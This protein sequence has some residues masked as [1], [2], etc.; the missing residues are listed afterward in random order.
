ML[1]PLTSEFFDVFLF[2][3]QK[4][5][6]DTPHSQ[7]LGHVT[8]FDGHEFFAGDNL[9]PETVVDTLGTQ[10]KRNTHAESERKRREVISMQ[11]KRMALNV[12]MPTAT[13]AQVM[14]AANVFIENHT[15]TDT[16]IGR[17]T[18]R[19]EAVFQASLVTAVQK[20]VDQAVAATVSRDHMAAQVA[21]LQRENLELQQRNEHL[22]QQLE[23]LKSLRTN[24]V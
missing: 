20:C 22:S 8:M 11:E 12:G 3:F 21:A 18:D 23:R 1:P 9:L 14:D 4:A 24:T 19:V 15:P 6:L 5:T 2:F 13:R 17:Y 10:Q 7:V 16:V